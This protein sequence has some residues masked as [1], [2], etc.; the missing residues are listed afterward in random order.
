MMVTALCIVNLSVGGPAAGLPLKKTYFLK[1]KMK[2]EDKYLV[3]HKLD[4]LKLTLKI[5]KLRYRGDEPPKELLR[6]AY[7]IGRLVGIS[8]LELETIGS[9][10]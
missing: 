3:D 4:Y 7:E 6:Q 8:E 2:M 5:S 1:M 9:S 10:E